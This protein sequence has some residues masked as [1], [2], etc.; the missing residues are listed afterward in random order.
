VQPS[1]HLHAAVVECPQVFDNRYK[2]GH[3]PGRHRRTV[4]ERPTTRTKHSSSGCT[5]DVSYDHSARA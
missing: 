3:Q 4:A 2:L 1:Q 5:L